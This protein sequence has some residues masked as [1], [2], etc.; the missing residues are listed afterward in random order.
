MFKI[1][2]L[3]SQNGNEQKIKKQL[4]VTGGLYGYDPETLE[5]PII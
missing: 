2:K 3:K 4:I 5:N 1:K